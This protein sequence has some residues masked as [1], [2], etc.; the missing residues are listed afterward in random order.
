MSTLQAKHPLYKHPDDVLS[1]GVNLT[2]WLLPDETVASVGTVRADQGL[3]VSNGAVNAEAFTDDEE[4]TCEP[5]YGAVYDCEGGSAGQRYYV[6]IPITT[7]LGR[8][9]NPVQLVIVEAH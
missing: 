6:T 1:F 3:T 2:P 4:E 8:V 5:D 9:L 7:S